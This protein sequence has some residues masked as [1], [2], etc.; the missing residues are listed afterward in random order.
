M[1]R[2][3]IDLSEVFIFV[4]DEAD[5]M[6][7]MGFLPQ[8]KQISNYL[9]PTRQTLMWSATWPPEVEE[10]S[11]KL[12]QNKPITIKVGNEGLTVNTNITQHVIITDEGNKKRETLRILKTALKNPADKV[13]IFATTK[14]GCDS[15]A[16]MLENE[17]FGALAIHGD[18]NQFVSEFH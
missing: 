2:G 16:Q 15:I 10:L 11:R 12:C 3:H 1:Q 17:G 9:K 14:R 4:L 18:K 8:V 6:L 13:L 7:D 5:R